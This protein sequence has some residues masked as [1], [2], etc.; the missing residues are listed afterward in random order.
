MITLTSYYWT[1]RSSKQSGKCIR[2]IC[3]IFTT[4]RSHCTSAPYMLVLCASTA[5]VAFFCVADGRL[6][7][8]SVNE[9]LVDVV[10]A[11]ECF[12]S[13]GSLFDRATMIC[14]KTA[15]TEA[16]VCTAG[17][18]AILQC[19]ASSDG[20][21]FLA[22]MR[23]RDDSCLSGSNKPILYI[24]G[25]SSWL[26]EIHTGIG[27]VFLLGYQRDWRFRDHWSMNVLLTV[28]WLLLVS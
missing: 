22:G 26:D 28:L 4:S 23:I 3:T 5:A 2:D 24:S 19:R 1:A 15:D 6:K 9:L 7:T 12:E 27:P 13:H 8:P 10:S 21:W 14:A 18:G 25:L 16:K 17:S 20:R 11:D